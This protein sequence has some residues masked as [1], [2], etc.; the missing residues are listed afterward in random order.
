MSDMKTSS[1]KRNSKTP[2]GSKTKKTVE[3]GGD[4]AGNDVPENAITESPEAMAPV[5]SSEDIADLAYQTFEAHGHQ[6]G[7]DLDDWVEA[8]RELLA[9][10][11]SGGKRSTE[12]RSPRN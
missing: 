2:A 3:S 5:L 9:T 4:K 6:H 10:H 1:R 8:E 11:A 7:R 12:K